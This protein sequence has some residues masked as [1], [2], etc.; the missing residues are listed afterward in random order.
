MESP[1]VA[2]DKKM[3]V[4]KRTTDLEVSHSIIIVIFVIT[5]SMLTRSCRECAVRA[6]SWSGFYMGLS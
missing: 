4:G 2:R 3:V 5:N 6:E 1:T